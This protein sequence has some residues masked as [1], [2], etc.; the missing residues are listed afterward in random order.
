MVMPMFNIIRNFIRNY[1]ARNSDI[2][3][4]KYTSCW[5]MFQQILNLNYQGGLH[6]SLDLPEKNY[7]TECRGQFFFKVMHRFTLCSLHH[8]GS[9]SHPSTFWRNHLSAN[10]TFRSMAF[11]KGILQVVVEESFNI[12]FLYLSPSS[13]HITKS[14]KKPSFW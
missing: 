7:H 6:R 12:P 1:V 4:L 5:W 8:R 3:A 13:R 10:S 9:H 11:F 14:S 2:A